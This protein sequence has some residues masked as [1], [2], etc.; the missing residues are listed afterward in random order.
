[1]K[2]LFSKYFVETK[3]WRLYTITVFSRVSKLLAIASDYL[4]GD[5][6]FYGSR[7]KTN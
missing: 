7:E 3:K 2:N 4:C 5:I 6:R 1:M